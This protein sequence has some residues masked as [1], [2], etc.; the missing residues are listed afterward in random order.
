MANSFYLGD[1]VSSYISL[2]IGKDVN[3]LEKFRGIFR[4]KCSIINQYQ[5]IWHLS[6]PL[7]EAIYSVVAYRPH[8]KGNLFLY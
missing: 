6:I 3:I 8:E 2:L 4:S 7:D 1:S 5:Q